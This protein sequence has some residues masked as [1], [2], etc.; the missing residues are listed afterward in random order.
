[1]ID[2]NTT[3]ITGLININ[4]D[5][6]VDN[7]SREYSLYLSCFQNTLSLKSNMVIYIDEEF[8]DFVIQERKKIDPSLSFT[9][10]KKI[11]IED[12]PKYERIDDIKNV[13]LSSGYKEGLCE[14]NAPEFCKPDYS[15]LILSKTFLL[16]EAMKENKF[17]SDYYIWLDAG[18]CHTHFNVLHRNIIYPS[19]KINELGEK[20]R[21]LCRS[22]PRE[23]DLNIENFYKSHQN[24]FGAGVIVMHKNI[25]ESFNNKLDAIIDEAISKNLIDSEQSLY[26]TLF[27]RNPDMFDNVH[28]TDWFHLFKI[29]T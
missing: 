3:I 12:L 1:M 22:T 7:Y 10:I 4:R 27:L 21:L 24:R 15:I 25:I 14:P 16:E 11:K 26:N 9:E 28:S 20:V 5:K 13:M 8:E 29:Y 19:N 23:E 6:W 18:I 2:N 17:D